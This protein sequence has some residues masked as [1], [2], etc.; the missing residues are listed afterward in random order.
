MPDYQLEERWNRF[1]EAVE[2]EVFEQGK[3]LLDPGLCETDFATRTLRLRKSPNSDWYSR[4]FR[5]E[6]ILTDDIGLGQLARAFYKEYQAAREGP[7]SGKTGTGPR[8]LRLME[9]EG[10]HEIG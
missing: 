8:D 10:N 5:R 2:Y 9:E 7:G 6:E 4:S 1:V 3:V